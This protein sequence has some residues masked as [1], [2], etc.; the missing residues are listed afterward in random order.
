MNAA[1]L[2]SELERAVQNCAAEIDALY[3]R[4]AQAAP[5][6]DVPR[7]DFRGAIEA[8]AQKYLAPCVEAARNET[9]DLRHA[10]LCDEVKRLLGELQ[11]DDL[12]L[13]LACAR[14]DE[15]AWWD[16]DR[17]HRAFIESVAR[18]LASS[19]AQADETVE[20]IYTELYGTRIVDGVRQSKF[21]TYAGRG[22]LR[23]WLRAVVWHATVDAHR[24]ARDEVS[25][26]AWSEAGGETKA[27]PGRREQFATSDERAMVAAVARNRYEELASAALAQSFAALTDHEKLLLLLY[28]VENLRLRE[29]ARLVQETNSPLRRWFQRQPRREKANGARSA[30]VHESTVMRWLEKVYARVLENFRA[31][32]ERHNLREEE[33]KIC[34]EL[35]ANESDILRGDLEKYL[36]TS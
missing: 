8:A 30:R 32:L 11:A 34:L 12:Y 13:A 18:H 1:S 9:G 16:F 29:I 27:R 31:E 21:A 23:G 28:H 19:A 26:E 22:S 17:K 3:A 2:I 36:G 10:R 14:G 24:A 6:Y 25:I 7:E 4:C 35:A 33:I 5:N 15:A 20:Y